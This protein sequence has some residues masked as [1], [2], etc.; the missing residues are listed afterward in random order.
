MNNKVLAI[1][2]VA[3][4]V[5]AA[6]AVAV[7]TL[8]N[9][10]E[11]HKVNI[12]AGNL[13][14]GNA[15]N[16]PYI[17]D[18][19]VKF[20]QNIIDGKASWNSTAN[21]LADANNDGSITQADIDQV[22]MIIGNKSGKVW[23]QTYL[24]WPMEITYPLVDRN[25]FV[26][27]WQQAEAAA[28]LGIWDD[29]KVANAYV[30]QVKTHQY[31]LSHVVEVESVSTNNWYDTT[32]TTFA[33][34]KIDLIMV[35]PN[36][37]NY[38]KC[39]AGYMDTHPDCEI[40][41][42]SHVGS[43]AMPA[44]LTMGI[45]F[46]KEDRA[47]AY[48]EYC[49]GA[50]EDIQNR[51]NGVDK[52]NVMV[53]MTTPKGSR[54]AV[55]CGIAYE[56]SVNLISQIANVYSGDAQTAYGQTVKDQLWYTEDEQDKWEMIFMN[57]SSIDWFTCESQDQYNEYFDKVA[58]FFEG[59]E[60]YKHNGMCAMPYVCGGYA[61]YAMAYYCAWYLYPDLFT[62]EEAQENLQYWFDNFCCQKNTYFG[63][64]KYTASNAFIY[65]TGN[66]YTTLVQKYQNENA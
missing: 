10:N 37:N 38:D 8:G 58:A 65:Y 12:E 36:Q 56:G 45:L 33:D 9:N 63:S 28:I 57:Y 50:I 66:N 18:D 25:I 51:I 49:Y 64:K 43:N 14:Y 41:L 23:Y 6:A 17:D 62:E 31:D 4:I 46:N 15:N 55:C 42:L 39:K 19:D 26:G 47:E 30:T 53:T 61:A 35:T 52:K 44:M 27:Y 13:V 5:I 7:M 20:I 54:T 22:N 40:L 21:P 29:V 11:K 32:F 24:G 2:I 3:I 34:E 16:D 59:T 48:A 60:A 1:V